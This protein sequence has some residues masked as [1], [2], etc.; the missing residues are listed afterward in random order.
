MAR[1]SPLSPSTPIRPP[2]NWAADS[3]SM[4]RQLSLLRGNRRYQ[5]SPSRLLRT[6]PAIR[7]IPLL[8]LDS[9]GAVSDRVISRKLYRTK[10]GGSTYYLLATFNDNTTITYNDT[11]PDTSLVTAY[12]QPAAGTPGNP[13]GVQFNSVCLVTGD[14]SIQASAPTSTAAV[15]YTATPTAPAYPRMHL[16]VTQLNF[17]NTF[18]GPNTNLIAST[19]PFPVV[20]Q[21]TNDVRFLDFEGEVFYRHLVAGGVTLSSAVGSSGWGTTT[22]TQSNATTDTCGTLSVT[23]IGTPTADPTITISIAPSLLTGHSPRVFLGRAD[24]NVGDG[25]FVVTTRSQTSIVLTFQGTP[26]SG[27]TYSTDFFLVS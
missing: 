24:A 22:V 9:E 20:A 15:D 2:A 8:T 23:A 26:V 3:T 17:A 19:I 10:V 13:V 7:L 16:A 18:A 6:T 14:I 27:R 21:N 1:I 4:A 25:T 5:W 11:S 12:S